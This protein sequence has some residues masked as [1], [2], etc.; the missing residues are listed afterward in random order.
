[1]QK[2]LAFVQS[3]PT[4]VS[5]Q[6]D[7]QGDKWRQVSNLPAKTSAPRAETGQ[8]YLSYLSVETSKERSDDKLVTSVETSGPA[9]Q[10][11]AETSG[12]Q[13]KTCGRQV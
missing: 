2:L 8:E 10:E 6:G 5:K 3:N 1:M 12:R 13:V 7:K 11:E 9:Y 4:R